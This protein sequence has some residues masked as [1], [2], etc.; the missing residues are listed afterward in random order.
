MPKRSGQR[1]LYFDPAELEY[2]TKI[3]AFKRMPLSAFLVE[4]VKRGV[5]EDSVQTRIAEFR[6]EA[7]L[8]QKGVSDSMKQ[9]GV[10]AEVIGSLLLVEDLLKHIVRS[11]EPEAVKA[12]EENVQARLGEMLG[13]PEFDSLMADSGFFGV[14]PL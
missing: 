11:R 12:I 9:F 10:S 5:L 3:A 1:T 7:A 4:C 8:L 2:L 6:A 13:R 14:R